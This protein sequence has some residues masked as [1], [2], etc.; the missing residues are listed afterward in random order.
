MEFVS[1]KIGDIEYAIY[2]N[3]GMH[4]SEDEVKAYIDRYQRANPDKHLIRIVIKEVP[5]TD[6]VDLEY[7]Y[8]PLS[9]ERI[10]RITGYLVGDMSK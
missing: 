2:S 10:R 6:E 5:G 1:G 7:S 4:V 3:S 8:K 9:F